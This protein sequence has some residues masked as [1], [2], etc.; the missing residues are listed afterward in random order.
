M[1]NYRRDYTKGGV[2]FF[3]VN[4][5]N[6]RR[7][8]LVRYMDEFRAAYR[9][10][11]EHYPFET[12]AITILPDHFHCVVK[13]PEGDDDY[14]RRMRVLKTN[15]S[16]RLPHHCRQPNR[17]QSLRGELGIWQRRFWEHKIRD[18]A[19]L[20]NHIFY[21][22]Y[23]PVKHGYVSQVSDWAHSSFHR[24]VERGLFPVHWGAGLPISVRDL[25]Q[26]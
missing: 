17:S 2:S 25:Y 15:F 7:D 6:R 22:Y 20:E 13:L 4:L 26:D 24:D 10:T 3:T 18:D 1:T 9:E 21:T 5:Q 19:D 23:N 11:L 16:K 12:L 14:S 8:W